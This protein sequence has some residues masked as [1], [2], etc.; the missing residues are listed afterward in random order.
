MIKVYFQRNQIS[1]NIPLPIII[2]QMIDS[3]CVEPWEVR[4]TITHRKQKNQKKMNMNLRIKS[5]FHRL[6]TDGDD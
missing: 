5:G 3:Y 4:S 2:Q 1:K 6:S